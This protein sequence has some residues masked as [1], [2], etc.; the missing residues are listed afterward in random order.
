MSGSRSKGLIGKLTDKVQSVV[1]GGP[2]EGRVVTV[3]SGLP[4]SGTSMMMRMLEA[5]GIDPLTD[6]ERGPDEDNPEGY[7]EYERVKGLEDGDTAW[8]SQAEGKAVKVVSALLK[9]LPDGHTYRV[10][11]MRRKLD[12]VLESQRKMLERRGEDPDKV[13]EDELKELFTRH[14]GHV[15][16]WAKGEDNVEFIYANYND[17]VREPQR[18][19]ERIDRFL[20]GG[21]DVPAMVAVVDPDLYRNRA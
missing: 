3:V 13:S 10:I 6:H 9:H 1:S 21:L 5:G 14:L 18:R 11:F 7:Y 15:E 19:L 16:S 20:G 2:D 12:E 4:R 8:V 17:I